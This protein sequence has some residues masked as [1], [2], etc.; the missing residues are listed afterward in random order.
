MMLVLGIWNLN[1]RAMNIIQRVVV[2]EGSVFMADLRLRCREIDLRSNKVR[3]VS[4]HGI[5]NV[6]PRGGENHGVKIA[7][8]DTNDVQRDR[9]H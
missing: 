4:V 6:M 3:G 2:A 8:S 7:C 5:E 1:L 9:S